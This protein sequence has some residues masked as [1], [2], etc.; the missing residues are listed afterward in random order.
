MKQLKSPAHFIFSFL[1]KICIIGTP[2]SRKIFCC[3]E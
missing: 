1:L 3:D 2:F